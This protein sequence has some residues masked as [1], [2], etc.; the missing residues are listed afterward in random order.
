VCVCVCVALSV[1]CVAVVCGQDERSQHQNR[2]KAMQVLRSRLFEQQRL[3]AQE[4]RSSARRAQVGSGDRSERVRTYN[5]LQDRVTDHRVGLSK[6]EVLVVHN[7]ASTVS[8]LC[9]L[10]QVWRWCH[11][12][13]RVSR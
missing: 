3:A 1:L 5:Y 4:S 13:W 10:A 11:A 12:G 9:L 2:T 7:T 8:Q 6:C